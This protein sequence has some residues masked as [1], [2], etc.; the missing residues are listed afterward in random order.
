V[1]DGCSKLKTDDRAV[2]LHATLPPDKIANMGI[3]N[4]F[5]QRNG[6]VIKFPQTGF[7]AHQCFVNGTGRNGTSPTISPSRKSTR[8]CCWSPATAVR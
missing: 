1:F 7:S 4:L 3:V 2:V 8:A 6:D 5:A